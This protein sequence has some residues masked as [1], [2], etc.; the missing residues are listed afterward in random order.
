M[1]LKF[2]K[3][4]DLKC[5]HNSNKIQ[6][7]NDY[8]EMMGILIILIMTIMSQFIRIYQSMKLDTFNVKC[9]FVSDTLVKLFFF[10]KNVGK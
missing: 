9:L 7:E 2:V 5:C 10:L 6:E 1:Y 3:L 8:C 4:V